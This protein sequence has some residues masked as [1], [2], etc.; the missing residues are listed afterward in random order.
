MHL[1]KISLVAEKTPDGKMWE[2][3]VL[4]FESDREDVVCFVDVGKAKISEMFVTPGSVPVG[5]LRIGILEFQEECKRHLR[6]SIIESLAR[7]KKIMNTLFLCAV[8]DRDEER[9]S[10]FKSLANKQN[11]KVQT[12]LSRTGDKLFVSHKQKFETD[13]G[14]LFWES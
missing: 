11:K 3:T 10:L 2:F 13:D 8:E 9:K 7:R 5:Y 6:I 4:F 14:E 12:L 1:G